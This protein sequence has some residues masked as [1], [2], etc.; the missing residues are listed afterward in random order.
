M[1]CLLFEQCL[2]NQL[3]Q[4]KRLIQTKIRRITVKI[5][6]KTKDRKLP[7]A[8][9]FR[10]INEFYSVKNK[11]TLF[12]ESNL[13]KD[14]LKYLEFKPDV[15]RYMT[16]PKS[17]EWLCNGR[18]LRY[19]PDILVKYT[20]GS[21]EFI[22]VKP[23]K[24]TKDANFADKFLSLTETFNEWQAAPLILLTCQKVRA[25]DDHIRRNH[26]YR[27]LKRTAIPHQMQN[28]G[29]QVLSTG[30]PLSINGLVNSFKEK[31][32]E[33][34]EAWTFIAKNMSRINFFGCPKL[35]TNTRFQWRS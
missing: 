3:Y 7:K 30:L 14:A 6:Q 31:G 11:R 29:E 23:Y 8:N 27:F 13:E 18:R 17:F 9:L 35:T 24:K 33:S 20:N 5:T 26:L 12:C 21:F 16:Q 4:S 2:R 32:L 28:I 34:Y 22:E 19:T 25:T 1:T 15:D 10:P